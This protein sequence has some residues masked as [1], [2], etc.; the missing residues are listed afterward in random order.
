[1]QKYFEDHFTPISVEQ[2]TVTN[3]LCQMF[4]YMGVTQTMVVPISLVWHHVDNVPCILYKNSLYV[5]PVNSDATLKQTLARIGFQQCIVQCDNHTLDGDV[6]MDI[7]VYE[8]PLVQLNIFYDHDI[9]TTW[10]NCWMENYN[11][12]IM[13]LQKEIEA[14]EAVEAVAAVAVNQR[15]TEEKQVEEEQWPQ[16]SGV[17]PCPEGKRPYHQSMHPYPVGLCLYSDVE[18]AFDN[19]T[20]TEAIFDMD[21]ISY[22]VALT[23][24][25]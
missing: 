21:H 13:E 8:V 9:A 12:Q 6:L 18:S 14:I 25:A 20:N 19:E 10:N 1:M 17:N 24:L 16:D 11:V 5:I 22:S 23:T 2:V 4:Y 3:Q 15:T 7:P